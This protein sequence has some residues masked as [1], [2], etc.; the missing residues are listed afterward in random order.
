MS[1]NPNAIKRFISTVEAFEPRQML[2][3]TATFTPA[4]G[5][6]GVF[7]DSLANVIAISRNAAGTIFVNNGAVAVQGGTPTVANTSLIQIFGQAGADELSFNESNGALPRGLIQGGS[8]NDTITT[9]SGADQLFGNSGDDFLLGKGGIDFLFG[10]D[11]NDVLIGGDA[12]DQCFGQAGDD[13]MIW[14]PGDDT[15]LNDG[16]SGN[17]TAQVNGGNGA[18]S[19]TLNRNGDRA[20]F[21]RVTPAPFSLDIGETEKLLLNMSGGG[22]IASINSAPPGFEVTVNGGA[23]NDQVGVADMAT[24]VTVNTGAE[25]A[26]GGDSLTVNSDASDA[27]DEP[28]TVIVNDGDIIS[29]L[30]VLAN[31]TL[32]LTD[33]AVLKKTD[34]AI[35]IQGTIDV[36]GGALVGVLPIAPI[37]T[38]LSRGYNNGAWN[39]TN[40]SGAINSSLAAGSLTTDA[41]GYGLGSEISITTIGSFAIAPTDVLVRYTLDGDANLD[42]TVNFNDLLRLSQNYNPWAGNKSWAQGNFNYITADNVAGAVGFADLLRLSQ[43]YNHSVMISFGRAS[44][45]FSIRFIK[46]IF[47]TIDLEYSSPNKMRMTE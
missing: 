28:A 25:D 34:G 23:G 41:V 14:N 11:D 42:Q 9:G 37:Q 4:S 38:F 8:D 33:N 46:E 13:V 22:D 39:G 43:N 16:D 5:V 15:D 10:G 19:F 32:R 35:N 24:P 40:S 27:G 31:G 2:A 29:E 20:R 26:T 3:V 7:G 47:Q 30:S 17:D 36:G 44:T 1:L 45:R 6:L 12:D 18:E 21:D